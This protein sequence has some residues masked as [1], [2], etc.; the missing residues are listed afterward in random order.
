MMISVWQ[1]HSV[2][3]DAWRGWISYGDSDST[4]FYLKCA[5]GID[6]VNDEYGR[7]NSM[8]RQ[9]RDTS[10]VISYMIAPYRYT[11]HGI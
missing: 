6:V 1:T 5:Y 7:L 4:V 8:G 3:R 11:P 10:N 2:V 9:D